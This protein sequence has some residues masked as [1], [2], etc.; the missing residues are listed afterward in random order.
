MTSWNNSLTYSLSSQRVIYMDGVFDL[1][2]V[3]HLEAIQQAR[4]MGDRLI[5]GV[6]GDDDAEGYKRRPFINEVDRC[7]ILRALRDVDEVSDSDEAE[8]SNEYEDSI[9]PLLSTITTTKV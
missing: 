9:L 6:T 1:F 5:L 8:R 7:A 3:G 2:H 4:R